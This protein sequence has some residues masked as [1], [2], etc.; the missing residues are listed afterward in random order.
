MALTLSL[1]V[2]LGGALSFSLLAAPS[3]IA[4]KPQVVATFYPL[5]Y[6]A[7]QIGGDR[8]DVIQLMPDNAEPHAWEPRPSDLL[9]TDRA[10]VFIYNGAGFEPWADNFISSLAHRD[11]IVFVDTSTNL[12]VTTANGNRLDP[13][14]WLD[15]LSAKVQVENI[16][17]GLIRANPTNATY[18]ESNA[19]ALDARLDALDHDFRVGLQNRTKNDF[20]TTH[21]GF[22]YLAFRY[23][24]DAH[25]AVGIS[26][27]Q[28][29]SPADLA[30]L[31]NLVR[32]LGL[33]Y[34]FSEPVF[35]DAVV[36]TIA[37]ETGAQVL[38][39]DGIHGRSGVHAGMDYFQ[40]M[41]TNL[42]EL[43][44]GLEVTS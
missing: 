36:R 6:F 17:R 20:V 11:S 23:G 16:L 15:P 8:V 14:F 43:R 4:G 22:D 28:E 44:I 21:E 39:L 37:A 31:T 32:S 24:L 2:V 1:I 27:D 42:A 26:A 38:V 3:A 30:A 18:F 19:A 12:S 7:E 41:Y 33:H 5:A 10:S 13:H 34:V 40:I 29:P 25:A 9:R 35:S